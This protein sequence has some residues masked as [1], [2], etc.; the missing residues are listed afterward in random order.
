MRIWSSIGR[1]TIKAR[2]ILS[3]RWIAAGIITS[4]LALVAVYA[5]AYWSMGQCPAAE[6]GLEVNSISIFVLIPR[7][8]TVSPSGVIHRAGG[9]R[10]SE[11]VIN[12]KKSLL[13]INQLMANLRSRWDWTGKQ[14]MCRPTSYFVLRCRDE[15]KISLWWTYEDLLFGAGQWTCP[16]SRHEQE[17]L[18]A[19]G[20]PFQEGMTYFGN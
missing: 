12:D 16:L 1:Q 15:K 13:I 10:Y 2:N 8:T 19:I 3:R 7:G 14:Y 9:V 11:T 17:S 5:F 6:S 20:I 18:F 4:V